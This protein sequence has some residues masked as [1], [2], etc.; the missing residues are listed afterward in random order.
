MGKNV[1]IEHKGIIKEVKGSELQVSIIS[2]SSCASCSVKGSCSVSDVEEKI[3]DVFVAN[4]N[5]YKQGEHVEVYYKQSLGFRALFIGYI[6]PF[7][8]LLVTMI[9]MLSFTENELFAG[10]VALGALAPY[11]LVVYL[12]K[13]KLKKTFSFSI[14]KSIVYPKTGAVNI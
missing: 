11:Y 9:I 6:L 5:E 10:L 3:V 2:H 8:V 7:L 14:K 4:P 1:Q 12:T 13:D